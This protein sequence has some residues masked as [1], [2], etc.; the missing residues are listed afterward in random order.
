MEE[1]V[2]W[3]V[4]LSVRP[5]QLETL[6]SL[7][8]ELAASARDEPGTLVYDW[9]ISGDG[10]TVHVYERYA[11]SEATIA[12]NRAFGERF[13]GRFLEAVE[14]TRFTVYGDPSPAAREIL[15]GFGATYLGAWG[16]FS[17]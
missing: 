4:E 17:R 6:R 15:D 13:A 14:P 7:M 11:D 10:G 8:E 5:G 3:V 9:Y 2:S 16:G 12:H 1:A